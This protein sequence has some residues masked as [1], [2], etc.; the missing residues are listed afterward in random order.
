MTHV[1]FR[2][3]QSRFVMEYL[4]V[5]IKAFYTYVHI[6]YSSGLRQESDRKIIFLLYRTII[7]LQAIEGMV[8]YHSP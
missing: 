2:N 6:V 4:P 5:I 3:I 8:L 7:D 1:K